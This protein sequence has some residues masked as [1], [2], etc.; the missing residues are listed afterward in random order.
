[1]RSAAASTP[2][3]PPT[4]RWS[5]RTGPGA[6]PPTPRCPSVR[7]SGSPRADQRFD[8]WTARPGPLETYEGGGSAGRSCRP[9]RSRFLQPQRR[10]YPTEFRDSR[11]DRQLSPLPCRLLAMHN[12][13]GVLVLSATDLVGHLECEHLTQ[14]ERMAALGEVKRPDRKDPALDLLSTL[15]EE[16]ERYHLERYS[17]SGLNV[18]VVEQRAFTVDQLKGAEAQ[19]VQAMR[20]GADVI[21]QGTFF[22]GRWTGRADFLIKV[23]GPS[24][25]GAH[26]YEVVDAKLARHAKTRALLQVAIYSDQLA[27]LQGRQPINMRLI[28]GDHIEQVFR[29]DDFVSYARI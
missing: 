26:S 21:Y 27:R 20:D 17:K 16:H 5:C 23:A 14:L 7:I 11:R 3:L 1:M 12:A 8:G 25:L 10:N 15:G 28:L 29:V 13:E 4:D 22:D 2:L 24:E 19:T 6:Q 9:F 18:V